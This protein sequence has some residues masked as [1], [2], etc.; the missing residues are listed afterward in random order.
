MFGEDDE[1][2]KVEIKADTSTDV[3]ELS[4]ENQQILAE[5][6]AA[7][8]AEGNKKKKEKKPKKKK[9]KKPKPKK[10]KKPKPPKPK[11]EKKPKEVDKTPPLPKKP[12]I[13]I[14]IMT[15]SLF[16]F[17]MLMTSLLGYQVNITQAKDACEE[18]SYVEAYQNL[19]GIEIK[20]KDEE[21][22]YKLAALAAVS[23]K[24]NS[25][26]IF[27]NSG[28][29]SLALDALICACGRCEINLANAKIYEFEPELEELK[30]K[31]VTTLLQQYD[32]TGEEALELYQS[33]TRKEYTLKLQEILEKLGLE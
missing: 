22:Y 14:V 3:S 12:V 11:K 16:G 29:K 24:Y 33:K 31:I 1:E 18:G 25:Y 32:M 20:E 6:E 30:G 26:L 13:A 10:E 21:L 4:E 2:E 9:E 28:K 27:E 7:G 15:A 5:L 8:E 17:V 19:Q 23:E